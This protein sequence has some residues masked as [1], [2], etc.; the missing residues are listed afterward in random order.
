[1]KNECGKCGN[2]RSF[3][4]DTFPVRWFFHPLK[5]RKKPGRICLFFF[6]LCLPLRTNA[7]YN[8]PE[9]KKDDTQSGRQCAEERHTPL[10]GDHTSAALHTT[11]P[12]RPSS[13]LMYVKTFPGSEAAASLQQ[14]DKVQIVLWF[15]C[16]E[17]ADYWDWRGR[18]GDGSRMQFFAL[19][20]IWI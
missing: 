15:V 9:R 3:I 10:P 7:N 17:W 14:G 20:T 6:L 5:E 18:E 16:M 2:T 1:M 19:R 12:M 13:I 4:G 8:Q 11:M